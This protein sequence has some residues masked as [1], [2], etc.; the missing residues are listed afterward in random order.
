MA[1]KQRFRCKG[2]GYNFTQT[3]MRG[4]PDGLKAL[5]VMLYGF[6]GVSM[7]KIAQITGVSTVAVYKWIKAA[8]ISAPRPA[9]QDVEI[10]MIDE[11]WH[12][13]DGKKRKF[14]SGKPM[15]LFGNKS[16]PGIWVAVMTE[17]SGS[18]LRK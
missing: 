8:A 13:V 16:S 15:I 1:G 17:A 3:G 9:A 5:A 7:S 4:K 11:M 14:G 2:C 18:L 6:A 10:V 12:Y